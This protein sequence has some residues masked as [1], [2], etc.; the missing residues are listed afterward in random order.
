VDLSIKEAAAR[1]GQ[2]ERH[3]RYLVDKK[4]IPARKVGGQWRIDV[5][6]LPRSAGQQRA[7]EHKQKQLQAAVED[8]LDLPPAARR[9]YSF[10]DLRA[11]RVALPILHEC[12]A[13]LGRDHPAT[14]ALHSAL[15]HLARGC[16]RFRSSDKAESYS[17]ARDEIS[18][19]ACELVIAQT[20]AADRLVELVEQ[21]LLS[22][23]A[24]LLRRTE[25]RGRP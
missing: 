23:V 12:S 1:L 3:V 7:A 22:A 9:R 11:T 25:R 21:E 20:E 16:H 14:L 8:A 10:R 15:E 2:S 24:G 17:C 19:C 4:R 6:K 18:R 13:A 5:A